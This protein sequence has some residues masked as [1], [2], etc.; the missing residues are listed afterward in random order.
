MALEEYKRK[1]R[2]TKTAEPRGK[3]KTTASGR[4]FVV[5]K[6]QASHL[7][8]DLRLEHNGVLKS[9]A[10]PKGPSL[11][12]GT[13]RLAMA[14][15]D[16]PVDYAEF[17]GTIPEGEYGGGTVMIWDRGTY[18]PEG[19]DDVDQ[20]LRDGELKLQFTGK[21]LKGSWVLVRTR[22]R[23]WLFIK[24]RDAHASSRDITA[25]QPRSVVSR[26]TLAQI[27]KDEG[28]NVEKAARGDVPRPA[29]ASS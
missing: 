14:V 27:A 29:A 16:H 7:H 13:K 1:R 3:K 4:L 23:Q 8:Y 15:E 17:E 5:Q 20:A 28:G 25:E 24:H 9:W 12:P 6:H 19:I 21:K 26:R 11:D 10:V 18:T 22:N 2:F